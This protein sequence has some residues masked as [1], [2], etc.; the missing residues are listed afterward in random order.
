MA[1]V[2]RDDTAGV[3]GRQPGYSVVPS[4]SGRG[5]EPALSLPK[6]WGRPESRQGFDGYR[7]AVAD[8]E[9]DA[10]AEKELHAQQ[11][12]S[13]RLD[14]LNLTTLA[15]PEDCGAV[16]HKLDYGAISQFPEPKDSPAQI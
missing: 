7:A 5:L 11:G 14:Y 12:V 13:A 16:A 9:G 1:W 3:V 4:P 8:V 6:G 10:A 2:W 15:I